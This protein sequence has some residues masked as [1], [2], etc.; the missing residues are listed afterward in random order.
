LH[1]GESE[2]DRIIPDSRAIGPIGWAVAHV[3]GVAPDAQ[4]WLRVSAAGIV[5][6]LQ[7]PNARGIRRSG[8]IR[9]PD[10]I[11]EITLGNTVNSVDAPYAA[12]PAQPVTGKLVLREIGRIEAMLRA[13]AAGG[14]HEA[15]STLR[16]MATTSLRRGVQAAIAD[17]AFRYLPAVTPSYRQWI[18][19]YDRPSGA[20]LA[21]MR[22]RAAALPLQPAFSVLVSADKAP[23][24]WVSDMIASVRGQVYPNWELYL[25]CDRALAAHVRILLQREAASDPRIKLCPPT[26]PDQASPVINSA[27]AM[28]SGTYVALLDPDDVL[29]PHALLMVADAINAH[30]D[31]DL[32]YSDEDGLDAQSR[33][34]EPYFKPSFNAELLRAQNFVNHLGVYRTQLLRDLGGFRVSG[35]SQ[36]YDMALRVTAASRQPV[37]HVPCILYHRRVD[38]NG[39]TLAAM[40]RECATEA[41]RQ[42]VRQQAASL[43]ETVTVVPGL[44][45]YTRVL[46]PPPATWPTVTAIV[47]TRDHLDVLRVCIDGLLDGTDYPA[48]EIMIVDNDSRESETR[49]YFEAVAEQGVRVLSYP[50]DFNYSAINNAAATYA[51]GEI[52]LLI[53]NDMSTINPDWLREM[54]TLM[55]RPEVGAVGAKLLFPDGTLQHGGVVLGM[56]GVAGHVHTGDDG[57]APGYFGRLQMVQEVACCTAACL[58]VW[59]D[60]FAEVGGFD[61]QNLPVAFNDVDLCTRLRAAGKRILWTPYATLT[62]FG[63]KSR[64]S[65]TLPDRLEHFSAEVAYMKARWRRELGS[66]PF[67]NPNL[68]LNDTLPTISFPPRLPR[69]WDQSL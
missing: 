13:V 17:L 7:L 37:I 24:S 35:C 39:Q 48:L 59:A 41:A 56:G 29:A 51:R 49:R 36:N 9:L 4:L 15:T 25:V 10:V 46:Y 67:F 50:G 8:L 28:A 38:P 3:S 6:H 33:R 27:L 61:E 14:W 47:P 55:L 58:T 65:D 57:H 12:S 45:H 63:S 22:T 60:A 1:V 43:G 52:L 26:P 30:P 64:G 20:Q 18:D 2:A 42:A 34:R 16:Q 53:N 32:L 44:G 23:G 68:S 66:D 62:H 19:L 31:A 40:Q 21:A 5:R 11:T 54:V 69:P